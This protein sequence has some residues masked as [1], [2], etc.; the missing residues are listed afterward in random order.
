MSEGH[1]Y[2]GKKKESWSYNKFWVE[3]AKQVALLN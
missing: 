1:K 2:W 3:V